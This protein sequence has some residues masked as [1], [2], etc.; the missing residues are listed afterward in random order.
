MPSM[1]ES[2]RIALAARLH[3]ALRRKHGRVTDTEWMATNA[4]YAAEIVRM[5]RA[6]AADTKDEELYLL[7]TR[8]E[9]AMEPLARAARLA[10]RQP[11]GQPPTPPPRYVGGLR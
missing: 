3:V 8:L 6:H 4:E 1:S 5:T 2:E 9:Q 7:A 10:A 11:D